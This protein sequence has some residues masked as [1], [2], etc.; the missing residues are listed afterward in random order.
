MFHNVEDGKIKK[1]F[2]LKAMLLLVNFH[3]T[4]TSVTALRSHCF[5][6]MNDGCPRLHNL[7]EDQGEKWE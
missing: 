3:R 5:V 4:P 1:D 7:H 2:S 6:H